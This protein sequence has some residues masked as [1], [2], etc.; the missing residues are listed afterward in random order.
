MMWR[1][2]AKAPTIGSNVETLQVSVATLTQSLDPIQRFTAGLALYLN[3]RTR[4]SHTGL[5]QTEIVVT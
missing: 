2:A 1:I 3:Q 5:P 4:L